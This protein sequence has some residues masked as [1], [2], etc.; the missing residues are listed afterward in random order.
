V[1]IYLHLK[2]CVIFIGEETRLEIVSSH[3]EDVQYLALV[4]KMR[5]G[6]KKEGSKKV[7]KKKEDSCFSN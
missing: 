5:K 7:P 4:E 2:A 3:N 6:G 1:R